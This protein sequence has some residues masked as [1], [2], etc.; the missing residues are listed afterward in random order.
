MSHLAWMGGPLPAGGRG[1]APTRLIGGLLNPPVCLHY[2]MVSPNLHALHGSYCT[3][4]PH[5]TW[6][7]GL[8]IPCEPVFT[9]ALA[10]PPATFMNRWPWLAKQPCRLPHKRHFE[11]RRL[12][13]SPA[14]CR[15]ISV[16]SRRKRWGTS[17]RS[18][19]GSTLVW[20]GYRA[21]GHF[22][23]CTRNM[24]ATCVAR[25]QHGN[26]NGTWKEETHSRVSYKC[27]NLVAREHSS[28][29]L[30][31][32]S[33]NLWELACYLQSFPF[34]ATDTSI[35]PLDRCAS[36]GPFSARVAK[37]NKGNGDTKAPW[38]PLLHRLLMRT[39][40]IWPLP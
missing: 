4:W 16:H 26:A 29:V 5:V 13:L 23:A 11:G 14:L 1:S 38:N 27:G 37:I 18:C 20:S 6:D 34:C 28:V 15:R 8:G 40:A 3:D 2:E 39:L 31:S 24:P 7:L 22:L 33:S 25:P 35:G 19:G 21:L 32:K 9:K 12:P 36:R 30:K 10:T 17:C